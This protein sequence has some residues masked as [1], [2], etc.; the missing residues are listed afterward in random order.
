MIPTIVV[1]ELVSS[2]DRIGGSMVKNL[3]EAEVCF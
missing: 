3:T 1:I 2:R